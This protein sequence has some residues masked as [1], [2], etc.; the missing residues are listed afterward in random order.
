MSDA[1]AGGTV[2]PILQMR[3][4]VKVFPGVRALDGVDL[5]VRAGEVHCL[6]GQNGAGKSTLIKV[7]SAALRPEEGTIDWLGERVDFSVPM[8]ALKAGLATMYQE[9]DLVEGLTVADNIFLGHEKAR[10]GWVETRMANRRASEIMERLGHPEIKPRM[11]VGNLSAAGQQ[12]VSMARA[13]SH[14][15]RLIVMD[16]PS[17]VLDGDEVDNLF[18]V[19][20]EL[21]DDGVAVIYISHRLEEIREV[22]DRVTVLKDGATVATGLDAKSTPTRQI[23][24]LMTGRDVEYVFPPSREDDDHL[25]DVVL[26]VDGLGRDGEFSDISFDV[27]AGEVVGLA[28]LVGSGRSEILET[29]YGAHSHDTGSVTFLGTPMK[30][31]SVPKAVATGMGLAP[32]ERKS[33]ALIAD[34]SIARNISLASLPRYSRNGFIGPKAEVDD[35]TKVIDQLELRPA[36]PLRAINTLSGG[37]QQKGVVARWLLKGCRLLLLDEPTRG[38]DV[39]ARAE[40]YTL[41][42]GL[43]DDG[44]GIVMVSSEVPE[45]LGMADRVLVVAEGHIVGESPARELDE[46]AVLDM[47]M[48][49]SSAHE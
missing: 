27:R 20:R 12:I 19:I 26:S 41:I 35:V 30:S 16:E 2:D 13:L 10:L 5:D 48:E 21:T 28:G 6:L 38:V 1:H 25:G 49:G 47:V 22:G 32:E 4:I 15:A 46:A 37:N 3:D 17:A 29:I 34:Q 44:V 36:D 31:A 40:L 8:E 33:Q 45:V 18:R 23:I 43:A 11:L 7:L 42:R 9:L 39:G 24:E 14:D